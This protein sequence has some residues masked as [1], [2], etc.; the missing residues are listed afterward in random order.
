MTES[1]AR[2]SW[3]PKDPLVAFLVG[4]LT[5]GGIFVMMW[6]PVAVAFSLSIP[7]GL[8]PRL[9]SVVVWAYPVALVGA[10]VAC[11]R[12]YRR[13]NRS[14]ARAVVLIPYLWIVP[15]LGL[16]AYATVR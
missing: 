2:E 10:G 8:L 6:L 1:P 15:I 12:A 11:R 13:G 14:A 3:K 5:I 4:A 7:A 9:L 16:L